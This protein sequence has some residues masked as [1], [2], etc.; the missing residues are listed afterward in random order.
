MKAPAWWSATTKGKERAEK[1]VAALPTADH[2]IQHLA[3]EDAASVR[4]AADDVGRAY[5]RIDILVN[6]AGFTRPVPHANLDAL[7]DALID[8]IMVA[9][10]RGPFS[11]IRAT[12][13]LLRV[14]GDSVIVNVSSISAFTGSGSNIA[15]C[16]SKAAL[17][18][19]TLSLARVLG[20]DDSRALRL[21]RRRRHRFRR[22]TRPRRAGEDRPGY[23]AQAGGRARGHRAHR[24]GLHHP[25]QGEHR[26]PHR[27]RRRPVPGGMTGHTSDIGLQREMIE[28]GN[29]GPVSNG[30]PRFQLLAGMLSLLSGLVL[31]AVAAPTAENDYPNRVIRIV[32]PF[33]PGG[34]TDVLAR[35][36]GQKLSE[37]L[38]QPVVVEARPGANGILGAQSVA[39]SPADGYTML[40]TTGSHTANPHV[41]KS[42]PY[43]AIKDFAPISQIAGSYGL[44]LITTMPVN[45]VAGLVALAKAKPGTLSYGTSGVGNLTHVA[46][47]LFEARAGI[48]MIAVP[49][50]T[51]A[52]LTDVMAGTVSM[53]FNSLITATPLVKQGHF[54]ALAITGD[55]RS[56]ALPDTPTMTEAGVDNYVLTG[57]FGILFP[58][59]VPRARVERI[60]RETAKALTT[61]ELRADRGGQRPLCRGLLARR[62]RRLPEEGLRAPRRLDG[63]ARPQRELSSCTSPEWTERMSVSPKAAN[64]I[65]TT[66]ETFK[67]GGGFELIFEKDI[68]VEMSDGVALRV[69]VFRPA[70]P[71]RYP[72]VMSHG[73]YGKDVHF[74][75]AF[76]PQWEKL[77]QIYP[78]ID[79]GQSTGRFL[80]WEIPD[81]ERWVPDGYVI[82]MAD[83]RG[84]GKSPGY[85]DP[86]QP[87]ENQDYY[88]LIEWAGV[89]P[90]SN[91]KVGLLGISYLAINQWSAAALCAAA[92]GGHLSVGRLLG[93]LS[94]RQPPRR[95]SQQRVHHRLVAAPGPVQS[96]R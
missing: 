82:V 29:G 17:D 40:L 37:A 78:E 51:P 10:V 5:G 56:P 54:K 87:R 36:L 70:Q 22:R 9:N 6:S 58:A 88:E 16:A 39:R 60:A 67:T 93:S 32:Q 79:R 44:A 69:N 59:G 92:P 43:D 73:V 80:R 20:P 2:R 83:T 74:S 19:M 61:P 50:N 35:G 71:G 14:G 55:R 64:E 24:H 90:W 53:T 65:K 96:A 63:R 4:R 48:S 8:G 33:P 45:S 76:K 95:H 18:T 31:G 91:G 75:H 28:A 11:V 13:P 21:A 3:V 23:A 27:R 49:Y 77:K 12:V 84:S 72:V 68:A 15:Y 1:L 66:V 62:V 30:M 42:L 41:T 89:Q 57:Y 46:G 26:H 38:G 34:S 85:L 81:P 86:R 94:R 7:D 52:L 47:R 25:S